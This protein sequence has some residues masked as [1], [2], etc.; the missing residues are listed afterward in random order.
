MLSYIHFVS[1]PPPQNPAR[2]TRGA[3][4]LMTLCVPGSERGAGAV[5]ASRGLLWFAGTGRRE[6]SIVQTASAPFSRKSLPS[7]G[8][9]LGKTEDSSATVQAREGAPHLAP[10]PATLLPA[11]R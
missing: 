2:R 4:T 9:V 1:P 10:V 5:Q 8:T 7:T 3:G 11:V 6:K